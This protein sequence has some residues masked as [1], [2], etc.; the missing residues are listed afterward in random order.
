MTHGLVL[1]EGLADAR[2]PWLSMASVALLELQAAV[3][4]GAVDQRRGGAAGGAGQVLGVGRD[5]DLHRGEALAGEAV[6]PVGAH[7][8]GQPG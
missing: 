8:L 2:L 1:G 6:S 5:G 4:A 3:G 7:Q